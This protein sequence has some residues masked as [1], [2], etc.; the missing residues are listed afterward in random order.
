MGVVLLKVEVILFWA[1]VGGEFCDPL[2]K[3]NLM[4]HW[5]ATLRLLECRCWL[6]LMLVVDARRNTRI[7]RHKHVS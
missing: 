2:E 7:L 3:T 5:F 6:V 1:L 4:I